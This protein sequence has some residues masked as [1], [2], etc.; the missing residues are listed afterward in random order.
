MYDIPPC[1]ICH[2]SHTE[3]HRCQQLLSGFK[4]NGKKELKVET[5]E[6]GF[7]EVNITAENEILK[8]A[9]FQEQT[10]WFLCSTETWRQ[11][12]KKDALS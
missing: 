5:A 11:I 10:F 2:L 8:T 1:S 6:A 12:R 7:P 3:I 4:Y 9:R